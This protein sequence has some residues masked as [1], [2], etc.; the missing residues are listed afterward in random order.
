MKNLELLKKEFQK[1]QSKINGRKITKEERKELIK[2][3]KEI[4]NMIGDGL[5]V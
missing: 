2:R 4:F 5:N 1:N 3:N